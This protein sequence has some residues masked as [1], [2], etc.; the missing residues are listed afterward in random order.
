MHTLRY[1]KRIASSRRI[2]LAATLAAVALAASTPS[3]AGG[4]TAPALCGTCGGSTHP[5][6]SITSPTNN[7][8]AAAPATFSLSATASG[9][10]PIVR[11]DFLANGVVV[12]SD[13]SYPYTGTFISSTPGTYTLTATA[14][15]ANDLAG[16]SN[17]RTVSVTNAI[18]S[19]ALTSPTTG[20]SMPSPGLLT[21]S[22]NANDTDGTIARVDFRSNGVVV[23]RDVSAPFKCIY[24]GLGPG[25]YALSAVATDNI[26][27][28]ATSTTSTVTVTGVVP[29]RVSET[30]MYSYD[31]FQR[32]CKRFNPE[33]GSTTVEYDAA[34]NVW[35]TIDSAYNSPTGCALDP[36]DHAPIVR[37]YDALNRLIRTT[38][39]W[40]VADPPTDIAQDYYPDGALRS[41]SSLN[42]GNAWVTTNYTYN[43][44]GLLTSETSINGGVQNTLGY[45]YDDNGFQSALTYP[46]GQIVYSNPDGLGR[47][48]K[49]VSAAGVVYAN[50]ITYWPGGAIKEIG[51][52][53]CRERV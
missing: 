14:T 13:S 52:A 36:W 40:Y 45:G 8:K 23:C 41:V 39:P 26:G 10:A 21:L 20:S 27:G 34:G 38:T 3:F 18:P 48:R 44:R 47:S 4:S 35:R 6:V 30:R 5:K 37:A 11:V 28:S 22:A 7:A 15:D 42:S 12:G 24:S 25:T 31:G 29:G 17:A 53:S 9:S 49:V 46:D 32:L 2:A 33:S 16:A 1:I 19:V 43:L 51:R 50:D